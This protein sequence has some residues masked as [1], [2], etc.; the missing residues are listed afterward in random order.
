MC[1]VYSE[2]VGILAYLAREERVSSRAWSDVH[3][4][5]PENGFRSI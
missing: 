4:G 5:F 1:F 2:F 3:A